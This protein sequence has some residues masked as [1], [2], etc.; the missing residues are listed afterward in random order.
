MKIAILTLI[1]STITTIA[2]VTYLFLGEPR[3]NQKLP[4]SHLEGFCVD[5]DK[6]AEQYKFS[7]ET[8]S[9]LFATSSCAFKGVRQDILGCT[10]DDFYSF[11]CN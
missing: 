2:M 5:N 10:G 1:L 4:E 7:Y 6:D 3:E 8:Q 11:Y 9:N